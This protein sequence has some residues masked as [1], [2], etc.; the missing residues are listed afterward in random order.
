MTEAADT[1]EIAFT[2]NGETLRRRVPVRQHLVDF[3]RL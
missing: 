1:L 2:V 3:L